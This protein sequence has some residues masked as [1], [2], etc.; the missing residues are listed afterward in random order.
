[1]DIRTVNLEAQPYLYID[2]SAPMADPAAIS[3]AMGAAFGRL[4]GFFGENGITGVGA[5]MAVYVDYDPQT[6][7][8]RAGM[9]VA[10]DDAA[11]AS[12]AIKADRLPAG[13]VFHF[14][15]VGPYATLRDSYAAAEAQVKQT[16][17]GLG[18][19]TWEVY[20]NAPAETPEA[21]LRTE[22]YSVPGAPW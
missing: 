21:D 6:L 20:V 13:E 16:G 10:V 7:H 14:S 9:A 19:P 5:P 17:K 1:M 4:M 3:A 15:H 18:A 2:G 8:F 22:I 11:K 12:G